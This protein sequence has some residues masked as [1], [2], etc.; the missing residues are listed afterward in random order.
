M[1]G[2]DNILEVIAHHPMTRWLLLAMALRAV[3]SVVCWRRCAESAAPAPTEAAETI[4]ARRQARWR[5]SHRFAALMVVGIALAIMGLFRLAKEG[6][7]APASL[8]MLVVGIYLFTTEP[9]RHQLADARDRV[10]ATALRGDMEANALAL[11]MQ[12]GNHFNLMAIDVGTALALGLAVL[13]L[14][15]GMAMG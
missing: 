2:L 11:A 12:R 15:A 6:D 8:L 13:A 7:A 4:E 9:V 10:A 3:W 1:T 14:N 5:H